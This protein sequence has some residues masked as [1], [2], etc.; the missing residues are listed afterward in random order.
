M[1]AQ[2]RKPV[3]AALLLMPAAV[4]FVALPTSAI[5]APGDPVVHGL[6]INANG[7]V[8]PG[9]RLE[10]TVQGT[11]GQSATVRLDDERIAIPLRESARGV[12]TGSYLVRQDDTIDPRG[13]IRVHI[14]SG[15]RTVLS[16]FTFPTSFA[17]YR[18]YPPPVA[19]APAPFIE[20]FSLAPTGRI[21]PGTELRFRLNG[22]PGGVA[23]VDI[24]GVAGDVALA[25]TRPGHYEGTYTLRR[26]DMVDNGPVIAT[27]RHGPQFVTAELDRPL[28]RERGSSM[29]AA[30]AL[31]PPLTIYSPVQNATVD[32]GPVL[33]QGRTAP[34]ANVTVRVD[35]V[36]PTYG[37]RVGVAQNVLMQN[38]QADANGNFSI[39][40]GP[41]RSIP[42]PGTRYEVSLTSTT[43]GTP[44]ESRMTLFQRG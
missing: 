15:S 3:L 35:A 41:A 34:W 12:Y 25:E 8:N 44:T 42:V 36:S 6:Q 5:A 22:A 1:K 19:V 28:F 30:P 4:T 27:L 26:R 16:N 24:P 31:P 43:G 33:I 14:G 29:G 2:L 18:P 17:E 40:F 32:G 13:L 11:P 20:R 21:E 37:N 7:G 23:T 10:F 38:I 39:N 9:S